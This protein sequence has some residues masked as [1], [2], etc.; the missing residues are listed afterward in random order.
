[1][2]KSYFRYRYILSLIQG[3]I[4]KIYKLIFKKSKKKFIRL[5]PHRH[6]LLSAEEGNRIIK[7]NILSG[8]PFAAVRIGGCEMAAINGILAQRAHIGILTKKRKKQLVYNAGFF[9]ND[10]IYFEKFA[11]L[12]IELSKECDLYAMFNFINSGYLYDEYIFQNG[13]VPA[14]SNCVQPYLFDDPWSSALKGKKVL[15][16]H[17]FVETIEKQYKNNREYLFK[18]KNV[19]PEFTLLTLKSVQTISGLKDE[20][21]SNWFEALDWMTEQALK[22]DFDIALIG[23]GAYGYPLALRI[24]KAGKQAIQIGG[25]TQLLFG[26]KGK[27][28]ETEPISKEFNE[29]WVRPNEN[30]QIKDK[31]SIEKG[32]YW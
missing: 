7:E 29:F 12:N 13:G 30:E 10:D 3:Y 18:N 27:R 11:D 23:C 32:C 5:K 4:N 31:N 2:N 14:F 28:W 19:L 16:I 8:K 21:F 24:K 1:M 9:P 6:K 15:V 20:R 17:P 26:I 25:A 22:L